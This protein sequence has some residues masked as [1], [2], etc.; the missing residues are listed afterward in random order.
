MW[1][2]E[3]NGTY[4]FGARPWVSW[5]HHAIQFPVVTGRVTFVSADPQSMDPCCQRQTTLPA[6]AKSQPAH[7]QTYPT[8]TVHKLPPALWTEPYVVLAYVATAGADNVKIWNPFITWAAWNS[9]IAWSPDGAFLA[10]R[11]YEHTDMGCRLVRHTTRRFR[12]IIYFMLLGIL[13]GDNK[14][15][16]FSMA[17]VLWSYYLPSTG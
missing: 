4:I 9:D 5:Q 11:R 3:I 15:T 6:T 8:A 16:P 2:I 17:T 12:L 10:I 1:R 13:E 14:E 7:C